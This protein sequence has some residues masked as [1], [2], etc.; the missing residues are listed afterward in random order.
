MAKIDLTDV[1]LTFTVRP[2]KRVTLKEYVVRLW[3]TQRTENPAVQIHALSNVSLSA[4]DGDRLGVI[5]HN[6]AGKST[7]LRTLAGIYPPSGGTVDVQ[8]KISSLF[9]ITLGF[10]HEANGWDNIL[11]R[12]YLQGETPRT[13][14]KEKVQAIA[15]FSEL[16]EFLRIPVRNYSA[17]M[18][19]RLA[20]AVAT[21][22]DP[23]I[24]LVDE[25]L[26]V[27]DLKF[28]RKAKARVEEMMSS[29]RL[30]VMVS[31]DLS[32]IK[33]M[34]NRAIWL[35]H[36]AV[37]MEGKPDEVVKAYQNSVA[38]PEAKAKADGTEPH[39]GGQTAAA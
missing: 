25:V 35:Q 5:G 3:R 6:G 9:D 14:R 39:V 2:F 20:F 10:E 19:M 27:G 17:G 36:G 24:L 18:L 29:A 37:M 23:E 28:Q 38:P 30:M 26:A 12:A 13:L 15:E 1:S 16:E 11:Y 34:C 21:S 33:S 7:L 31:H 8:G 4:R 22:I 32:A